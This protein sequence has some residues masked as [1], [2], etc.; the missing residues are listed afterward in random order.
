MKIINPIIDPKI[1]LTSKKSFF[2]SLFQNKT[3]EPVNATIEKPNKEV[4]KNK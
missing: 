2:S 4:S 1:N 3:E